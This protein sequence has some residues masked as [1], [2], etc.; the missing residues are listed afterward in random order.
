MTLFG[1]FAERRADLE[2]EILAGTSTRRALDIVAELDGMFVDEHQLEP[3]DFVHED[4][5][6]TRAESLNRTDVCDKMMGPRRLTPPG[7][8]PSPD[9]TG[10][11]NMDPTHTAPARSSL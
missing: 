2:R 5:T 9:H 10:A 8:A 7:P 3:D 11:E 1:P 4:G 6:I